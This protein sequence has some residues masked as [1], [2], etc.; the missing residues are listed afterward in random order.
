V[1]WLSVLASPLAVA[2]APRGERRTSWTALVVYLLAL[3]GIAPQ[4]AQASS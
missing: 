2:G 3:G 1:G 4:I